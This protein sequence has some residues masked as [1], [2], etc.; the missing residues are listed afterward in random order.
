MVYG[1]ECRKCNNKTV[2]V[3]E[4][5][6]TVAERIKEHLA[7]VR[8]GREKTV[9]FHF[10]SADHEIGDLNLIILEKCKESSRLYR[11]AR[12]VY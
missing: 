12:E 11:K 1:I 6:R 8:H 4:T 7:D 3:G 5:E 10:N 2:Y 9:S